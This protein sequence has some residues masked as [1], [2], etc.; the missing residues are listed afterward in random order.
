MEENSNE[1]LSELLYE[2][3]KRVLVLIITFLVHGFIVTLLWN[4]IIPV[5]F[6][7]LD[8]GTIDYWYSVGLVALCHYLLDTK[9]DD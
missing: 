5:I 2:Y 3:I 8:I 1:V 9:I 4:S 7:N 6:A